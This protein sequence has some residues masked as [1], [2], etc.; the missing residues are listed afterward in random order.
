M[1]LGLSEEL[2]DAFLNTTPISRPLVRLPLNIDGNRLAG[3]VDGEGSF[4]IVRESLRNKSMPLLLG[5]IRPFI[6]CLP[7]KLSVR[8]VHNGSSSTVVPVKSYINADIDKLRIIQEN[9][10]KAG[11]YL[12]RNSVN[13]KT[14]I[15][16]SINLV[17]RLRNYFSLY[18]LEKAI[19]NTRM[20]IYNALLKYGYSRFNL[21]ILE[22]CEPSEAVL[23]E[24]YY[25]DLLKPEYNILK[26]AGSLLGFKHSPETIAKI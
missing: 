21:E 22:Y 11:V 1:N 14:Y 25:L 23:R 18:F 8:S 12:F 2:K 9:K 24:Q 3:F 17:G 6:S 16:S 15:G 13:G 26:K 7:S 19:N 4:I 20:P 5:G 10:G